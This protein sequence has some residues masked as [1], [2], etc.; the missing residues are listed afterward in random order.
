[1]NQIKPEKWSNEWYELATT[2][3]LI[4]SICEAR[5]LLEENPMLNERSRWSQ[6]ITELSKELNRRKTSGEDWEER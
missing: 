1:M 4:Q 3:Q 6:R 2:D 5:R